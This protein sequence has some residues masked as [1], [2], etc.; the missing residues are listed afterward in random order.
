MA[1]T[2]LR[3]VTGGVR[4]TPVN[5]APLS[6]TEA[7]NRAVRLAWGTRTAPTPKQITGG[8]AGGKLTGLIAGS[9][10]AGGTVLKGGQ[11]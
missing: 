8:G 5:T 3:K 4:I 11:V 7:Q 1:I 10:V 6:R 2:G 9:R